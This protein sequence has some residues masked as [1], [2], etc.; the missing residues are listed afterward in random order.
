M[1]YRI[2][3]FIQDIFLPCTTFN[4]LI[5]LSHTCFWQQSK[6]VFE[7]RFIYFLTSLF[8]LQETKST[9]ISPDFLPEYSV[10][11]MLCQTCGF[12][13]WTETSVSASPDWGTGWEKT[14][15][16]RDQSLIQSRLMPWHDLWPSVCTQSCPTWWKNWQQ[17]L[18]LL[19]CYS[20]KHWKQ[21]WIAM[22]TSLWWLRAAYGFASARWG[23]S[24]GR[25]VSKRTIC[26]SYVSLT[27]LSGESRLTRI[28]RCQREKCNP[29]T[30]K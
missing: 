15:L 30:Y 21:L 29:I 2:K 25:V 4:F 20:L 10:L 7:E 14:S 12:S 18:Y 16:I 8:Y 1:K 9:F 24:G 27:T 3:R 22:E 13:F 17:A 26:I 23:E 19:Y 5:F 6:L 28:T 11:A